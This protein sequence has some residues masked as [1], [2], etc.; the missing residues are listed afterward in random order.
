MLMNESPTSR[1]V[2]YPTWKVPPVPAS[3]AIE[4]RADSTT[5]S[6]LQLLL[7]SLLSVT[8]LPGSTLQVPLG[9]VNVPV[10]LAG[11]VA[12]NVTV[13]YPPGAMPT[14]LLGAQF[15]MSLLME[16][17]IVPVIPLLPLGGCIGDP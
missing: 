13:K 9:L 12:V 2:T 4:L 17:S 6:L 16:Q 10:A 3:G 5:L 1:W 7:L 11:G 8:A 14:E 15:R